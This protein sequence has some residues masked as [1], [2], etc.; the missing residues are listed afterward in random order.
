MINPLT[1][2]VWPDVYPQ[3]QESCC[4]LQCDCHFLQN[5]GLHLQ[6]RGTPRVLPLAL[7]A[8]TISSDST[9]NTRGSFAPCRYHNRLGN[10]YR[11]EITEKYGAGAPSPDKDLPFH[12]TSASL[13]E[14]HHGGILFKV[15][16]QLVTPK[17]STPTLKASGSWVKAAITIKPP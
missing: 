5:R 4:M 1:L 10:V 16:N 11:H 9:F 2:L 7:A 17:I 8:S 13:K 12:H 15:R 14:D 3:I 6:K